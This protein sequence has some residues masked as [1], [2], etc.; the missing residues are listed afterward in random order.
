MTDLSQRSPKELIELYWNRV[1]NNC[2][3]ELIRE[4]CADPIY[5]HDAGSTTALSHDEQV[6]RVSQQ[7]SK[8]KPQFS[9]EVLL[10]DDHHVC[11]VW[12]MTMMREGKEVT[13]SGIEVFKA[14][15]GRFYPLLELYLRAG[16]LG[17]NG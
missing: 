17:A 4:I 5:R 6:K 3:V 14:E 15:N 13:L 16:P 2:E 7:T 11:S 8:V 1:W 9:H 12:N 10:A